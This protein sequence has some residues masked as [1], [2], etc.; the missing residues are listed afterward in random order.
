[1]ELRSNA[2][3]AR[4]NPYTVSIR[5]NDSTY[6]KDYNFLVYTTELFEPTIDLVTALEPTFSKPESLLI[7]PNPT[8]SEVHI[9][10]KGEVNFRIYDIN[11]QTVKTGETSDVINVENLID[12]LYY[13]QVNEKIY[14]F[15]KD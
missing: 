5:T 8:Q 4:L 6:V 9:E 15:L 7:Y 3:I 11:G 12:G 13:I 10:T 14:R 2:E 1:M